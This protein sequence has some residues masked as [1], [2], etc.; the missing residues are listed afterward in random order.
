[1]EIKIECPSCGQRIA[2]DD[3]WRGRSMPCPACKLNL[4]VPEAARPKRKIAI[5]PA[6]IM[7]I[8]LGLLILSNALTVFFWWRTA[9]SPPAPFATRTILGKPVVAP[10][11][12][13]PDGNAPQIAARNDKN[14]PRLKQMLDDHPEILTH[15]YGPAG[16]ALLYVAANWGSVATVKELLDRKPQVNAQNKRGQT[17]LFICISSGKGTQEIA[18]ALISAGADVNLPDSTGKSPLKLA[19]EKNRQDMI[20]LLK[21]HGAKE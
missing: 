6:A 14:L 7:W 1:M 10:A 8:I 18:S 15:R 17:A 12:A 4:R 11:P 19:T 9:H 16:N 2:V 3:S 20:D 21:Q 13:P 5:S